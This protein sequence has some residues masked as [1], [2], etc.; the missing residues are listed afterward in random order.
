MPKFLFI[1]ETN[2]RIAEN[3]KQAYGQVKCYIDNYGNN[4]H[5]KK[6]TLI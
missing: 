1:C 6:I 3:L 2:N 5:Q 4:V